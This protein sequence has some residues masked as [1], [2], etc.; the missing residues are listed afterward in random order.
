MLISFEKRFL[1]TAGHICEKFVKNVKIDVF[2]F[3]DINIY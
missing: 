2:S 1:I 3:A